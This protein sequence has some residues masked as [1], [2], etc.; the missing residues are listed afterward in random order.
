MNNTASQSE[1]PSAHIAL[2]EARAEVRE[3][4][5][6]RRIRRRGVP[7]TLAMGA[8]WGIL[9]VALLQRPLG[10]PTGSDQWVLISWGGAVFWG[11][12]AAY[13]LL[14]MILL[15]G[16]AYCTQRLWAMGQIL[17][18]LIFAL[19]ILYGLG[20]VSVR[21]VLRADGYVEVDG[22]QYCLVEYD[23][24][25]SALMSPPMLAVRTGGVPGLWRMTMLM[26][27]ETEDDLPRELRGKFDPRRLRELGIK[28]TEPATAE[29]DPPAPPSSIIR[30]VVEKDAFQRDVWVVD[31][32]RCNTT[33][34]LNVA[35]QAR[36]VGLP[37]DGPPPLLE[38]RYDRPMAYGE[39]GPQ[40][41]A[42]LTDET[43]ALLNR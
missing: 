43:R 35:I 19:G 14:S 41:D 13:A 2:S 20:H 9:L 30:V 15:L 26:D 21:A 27:V 36:M 8:I 3:Q 10:A 34:A 29:D 25:I 18:V 37:A 38:I 33:E 28:L 11:F 39:I 1:R 12:A 6:L 24:G 4:A 5:L 42:L 32:V 17:I 31:G 7:I 40:L 16:V 23:A 22:K